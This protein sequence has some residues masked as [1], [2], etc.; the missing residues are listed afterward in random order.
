MK[1]KD[2]MTTDVKSCPAYSTLNTAA[3]TMWNHDIGCVPIV[4]KENRVIGMLTDRDISMSAYFQGVSLTGALVTSAM[5]KQ[6]FAC[7][8]EDDIAAAEKLMREKQVHR[9][10][11]VDTQGRLA[12]LISLNDIAREAVQEAEMRKPRQV[13]DAEIAQL[14]ASVSAPR[15]RII[16]AQAA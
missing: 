13:S 4:D 5:S 16:G 9:L 2:L 11:V 1:V 15:H 6:V 8:P 12:G 10:P 7:R 3:Q 14:M